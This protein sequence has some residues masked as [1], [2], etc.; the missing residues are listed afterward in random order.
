MVFLNGK[1]PV[2]RRIGPLMKR[3]TLSLFAFTLLT[4]AIASTAQ[5]QTKQRPPKLDLPL[6]CAIGMDCFVQHYIDLDPSKGASDYRCG[7]LTYDNHK[8][9]DIRLKSVSQM[10][11]GVPV[12]A[13]ASGVVANLRSGVK[14]QYYSDYSNKKKKE[15]YNIGLGNVIILRHP[16]GW[17]TYY[18]HLRKGSLAVKIGQ[19]VNT[20]DILG[21]VGMSGL[22]DFPH[23]HFE[24]R[25]N[26]KRIDPFSGLNAGGECGSVKKSY[27]TDRALDQLSYRPTGF[28]ATG[29]SETR[30]QGRKDL[31]TGTKKQEILDPAA[32][33]LFFWSYYIGSREGD[34]TRLILRGPEGTELAQSNSEPMPK[35]QISRTIFVGVK[36]PATGWKPG[37]YRGEITINGKQ[38]ELKD[39]AVITVK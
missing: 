19:Q 38:R 28:M 17:E 35:N 29:F 13:A 2:I 3:I 25:K 39:N 9:T 10:T 33:T 31:E 7:S 27:W 5:A 4:S 26:N 16:G 22:T 1:I 36:R 6:K 34:V 32:P 30:P 14:D 15:I 20:G 8:G 18:A 24:L 11:T 37:L 12:I 21:Y 23:V